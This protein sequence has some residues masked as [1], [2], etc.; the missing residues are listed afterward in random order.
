MAVPVKK[1]AFIFDIDGTI[2]SMDYRKHLIEE[3]QQNWEE[4][5]KQSLGDKPSELP[6]PNE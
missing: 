6:R 3:E 2:A 1:I 4:F 5:Y